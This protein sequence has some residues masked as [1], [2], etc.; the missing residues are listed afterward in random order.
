MKK[1]RVPGESEA[2]LDT[3]AV[4]VAEDDQ[5]WEEPEIIPRSRSPRPG[6]MSEG[7]HLE[8]A[9]KFHVLS[10]L[11]RLGAEANL[12]LTY[13]DSVDI[14]VVRESGDALTIDVKT[15]RGTKTWSVET[16]N[17]RKHHFVVFVCFPKL[18]LYSDASPHVYV[19]QSERLQRFIRT[20]SSDRLRLDSLP[21]KHDTATVWHELVSLPAP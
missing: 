4:A 13:R 16:F 15:L 5:A 2:E 3:M 18:P 20:L 7:R 19:M 21:G 6:W 17:A 9:A 1:K 12:T 11:H 8:L 14:T 10:V